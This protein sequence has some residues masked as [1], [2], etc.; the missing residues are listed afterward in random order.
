MK[1]YIALALLFNAYL[2]MHAMETH[3]QALEH[4]W[5]LLLRRAKKLNDLHQDLINQNNK[6]IPPMLYDQSLSDRT[7]LIDEFTSLMLSPPVS[8]PLSIPVTEFETSVNDSLK[9]LKQ[10]EEIKKKIAQAQAQK[11]KKDEVQS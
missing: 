4:Q 2:P 9:Y 1:F 10:Y 8:A 5:N 6:S 11:V 3:I 7:V